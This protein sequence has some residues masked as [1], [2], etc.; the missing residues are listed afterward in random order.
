MSLYPEKTKKPPKFNDLDGF[1]INNIY[2]FC[3]NNLTFVGAKQSFGYIASNN[4]TFTH[5]FVMSLLMSIHFN[6]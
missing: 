6:V 3:K 2:L 4:D 5:F 1:Q